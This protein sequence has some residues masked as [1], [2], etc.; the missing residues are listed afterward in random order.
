L[1]AARWGWVAALADVLMVRGS[2][3]YAEARRIIGA[4]YAISSRG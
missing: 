3:T 1:I 4:R 2:V